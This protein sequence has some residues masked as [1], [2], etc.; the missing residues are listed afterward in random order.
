ME[1]LSQNTPVVAYN[2]GGPK[3]IIVDKENGFLVNDDK[4]Y[5]KYIKFILEDK[6]TINHGKEYIQ[7]KFSNKRMT[8]DF[9]DIFKK[10]LES[11]I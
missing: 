9:I 2:N 8:N 7:E 10:V 5:I 11:K 6:F 4:E 1:A 3:E